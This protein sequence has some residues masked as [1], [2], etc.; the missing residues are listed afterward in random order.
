MTRICRMTVAFLLGLGGMTAGITAPATAQQGL[1]VAFYGGEWGEAIQSCIV[2]P[3]VKST[4]IK[5][6]PEPGVSTVTL[7]K[8]RQQKGNPVI[9]IAWMDGGVSEL[10]AQDDLV[11]PIDTQRVPNVANMVPE[12]VYK[13]G[14]GTI[15]ALRPASMR[16]AL[17][18]IPRT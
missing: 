10:A 3:F 11:A 12:G 1:T 15:Y 14:A 17:C 6:T 16:S 13:T 18:I 2:D 4:G 8:L 9:D 5:V 7:A